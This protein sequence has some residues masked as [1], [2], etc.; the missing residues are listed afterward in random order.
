[1]AIVRELITLLGTE[2]DPKG[3]EQYER[4]VS[5]V[6]ELAVGLGKV[7]GI[8][9]SV[10]KILEFADGIVDTSKEVNRLMRQL[11]AIARPFDDIDAAQKGIFETAQLLGLEYKDV[12]HTFKEFYNEMTETNIPQ[13]EILNT[14]E[15]IYK[16]LQI[17]AASAEE[18]TQTMELFNR[19]F[20][21]GSFRSVGIGQLH[22]LA[23]IAFRTLAEYYKTDEKGLRERAKAGKVTAD[24]IVAAFGQANEKL[25]AEYAKLPQK[26][27]RVFARIRNDIVNVTSQIYKMADASETMG[28]IV[29]WVWQRIA[30]GFKY[31]SD[32]LG[33]LKQT[34]ELVSYIIGV[35]LVKALMTATAWGLRWTATNWAAVLPWLAMTAAIVGVALAIQDLVYWVQG[36]RNFIGTWVGS[37]ADLK[38]NFENLDIFAGFRLFSDVMKGDWQAA[39]RDLKIALTSTQAIVAELAAAVAL[40]FVAWQGLRFY[41]LMK[42]IGEILGLV[43][44]VTKATEEA[45]AVGNAAK[46][47]PAGT[48]PGSKPSGAGLGLAAFSFGLLALNAYNEGQRQKDLIMAGEDPGPKPLDAWY[49]NFSKNTSVG[50]GYQNFV[51]KYI[52]RPHNALAGFAN[53]LLYGTDNPDPSN[54]PPVTGPVTGPV[55]VPPAMRKG[56]GGKLTFGDWDKPAVPAV[57]PGALS[58]VGPTTNNT[59]IRPI[60]NQNV[61]G[62]TV[63]AAAGAEEIGRAVGE[64]VGKLTE[65]RFNAFARDLQTSGPRTES[66]TQ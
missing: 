33:G 61:G 9:F 66:A 10:D 23:P 28:R 39:F 3:I 22:D 44:S 47:T 34:V 40:T 35:V 45:V 6:K 29:W 51:D 52:Q 4:G 50:K 41:G 58:R 27:N 12:L 5:R 60:F 59:D 42:S 24:D 11:R 55:V 15:N 62:I 48:T 18:M 7:I 14:T 54:L 43:K 37:F 20:R 32:V 1:L 65:F 31:V 30:N 13:Q 19:S 46:T 8:A 36:K 25:D 63:N 16:A 2:F 17:G 56:S 49:D 53:R 57:A 64:Q 21:R 26:L 38:K